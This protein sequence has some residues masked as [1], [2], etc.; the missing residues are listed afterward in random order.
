MKK[1]TIIV[2]GGASGIGASIVN[3]LASKNLMLSF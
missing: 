2:S 1:K 3:F